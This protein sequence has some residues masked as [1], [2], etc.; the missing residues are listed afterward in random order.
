MP[1][2]EVMKRLLPDLICPNLDI[3][4]VS[5]NNKGSCYGRADERTGRTDKVI[6]QG[7]IC[8]DRGILVVSFRRTDGQTDGQTYLKR[9]R[10]A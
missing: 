4:I 8:P 1:E 6:G 10:R 9:S 2:E 7:L 5:D 3:L